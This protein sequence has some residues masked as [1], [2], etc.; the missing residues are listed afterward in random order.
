MLVSIFLLIPLYFSIAN[1]ETTAETKIDYWHQ[2]NKAADKHFAGIDVDI[3]FEIGTV[4]KNAFD[5]SET[6][7]YGKLVFSVPL[8]SKD[9][10]IKRN[11]E[12]RQFLKNGADLIR[13]IEKAEKLIEQ[14]KKYLVVLKKMDGEGGLEILDK[15]MTIQTEMIDFETNRDAAKRKLEGYLKCSENSE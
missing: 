7:Q 2:L 8:L 4:E 1:A 5:D 13:E 15:I 10:R 14:R 6:D 3:K 11:E 12:K 9:N